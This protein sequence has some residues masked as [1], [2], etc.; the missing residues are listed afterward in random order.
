MKK[1]LLIYLEKKGEYAEQLKK[2][3][4]DVLEV[5][6]EDSLSAQEQI[7]KMDPQNIVYLR[8]Y[9]REQTEREGGRLEVQV[10]VQVNGQK[11]EAVLFLKKSENGWGITKIGV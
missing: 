8:G 3:L 1:H 6:Q 4:F 9:I 5:Q 2:L 11:S 7:A 10:E